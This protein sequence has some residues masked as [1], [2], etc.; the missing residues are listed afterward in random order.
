MILFSG[1]KQWILEWIP[2]RERGSDLLQVGLQF[3]HKK[4][5][6]FNDKNVFFSIITINL[7][8]EFLTNNLVTFKRWDG[9][10]YEEH[11]LQS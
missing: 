8:W 1:I 5:T 11:N 6:I 7:K 4:L 2:L 10:K 9:V 3:S